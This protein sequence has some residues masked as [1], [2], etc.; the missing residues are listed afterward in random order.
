MLKLLRRIPH[1]DRAKEVVNALAQRHPHTKFVSIVGDKCIENLPDARLPMFII[2]RKG[3]V[4]NQLV[5]WGT[6]RER[7]IEG[8]CSC[9]SYELGHRSPRGCVELEAVLILGGAI[10]P[11]V[12][13]QPDEDRDGSDGSDID[14]DDDDPS[15]RMPSASTRT[16][17]A[18]PKNLRGKKEDDS[19]SDFEFDL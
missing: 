6:H 1:S 14:D 10:I 15:S 18:A 9:R 4:L 2:Y 16:N 12:R 19:D 5:S 11:R 13:R 7:R 17:A 3:E 8:T